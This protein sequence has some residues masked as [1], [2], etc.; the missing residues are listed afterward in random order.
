MLVAG[1]P[2]R[3][4]MANNDKAGG[5]LYHENQIATCNELAAKF[6]VKPLSIF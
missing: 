3:T 5:I 6:G 2:E 4:N 1:D